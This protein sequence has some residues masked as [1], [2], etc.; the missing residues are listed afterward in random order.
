MHPQVVTMEEKDAFAESVRAFMAG[1]EQHA[2][3]ASLSPDE[4]EPYRE[5]YW[6][7]V[8]EFGFSPGNKVFVDKH[9]LHTVKLPL[10]AALFPQA[11]ILFAVRDPRDVV[12]SCLRARFR[13]NPYMIEL[14]RLK[15]AAAFYANIMRLADHCRKSLPLMVREIRHEDLVSD[16]D[17]TAGEVCEFLGLEWTSS[18]RDFASHSHVRAIATPSARD[19]ARGLSRAGVGRWRAY[20]SQLAPVRP[21]LAPWVKMFGYADV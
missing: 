19:I 1:P 6:R 3:L 4:L 15:D 14:L 16:F 2:T 20:A 17:K 10:I 13:M 8:G 12:L 18:M 11:K 21:I 5:A 7:H 9:P